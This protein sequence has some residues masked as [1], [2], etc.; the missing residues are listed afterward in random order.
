MIQLTHFNG[1]RFY[2]NADLIKTIESTPD[3]IITLIN[4]SKILVKDQAQDVVERI[5]QYQRLVHNPQ[6]PTGLGEEG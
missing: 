4:D 3:T 2:L 5:I 1:H 6:M